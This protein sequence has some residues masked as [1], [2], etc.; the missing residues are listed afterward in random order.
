[1]AAERKT[2]VPEQKGISLS[3]IGD[4]VTLHQEGDCE[5]NG[6]GG[7][8]YPKQNEIVLHVEN[9]PRLIAALQALEKRDG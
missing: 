9:L 4:E 5:P 1:M 8:E 7:P 6:Y 3:V 2:I